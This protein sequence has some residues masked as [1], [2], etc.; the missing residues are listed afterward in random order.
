MPPKVADWLMKEGHGDDDDDEDDNDRSAGEKNR[1]SKL[2]SGVND[3]LRTIFRPFNMH[4][5]ENVS[6]LFADIVGFTQMS[7]NKTAEQ[8]VGLL[9]DLFGRFDLLCGQHGCEKISTLG[10][11]YYC[12]AGCPEPRPD[13]AGCCVDMGLSMIEA[14]G[15]FDE[16]RG[17]NVSMRVGVH[18]GTVLCGIVGVKRFKFDVWSN[19]VTLANQME[20]TGKPSQVHVTQATF[21]LLDQQVYFVE[22]GPVYHGLLASE[23]SFLSSYLICWFAGLKT[24]FVLGRKSDQ[25]TEDTATAEF[26]TM[27][28]D[29]TDPTISLPCG[30]SVTTVPIGG[31][32]VN[33]NNSKKANSLPSILDILDEVTSSDSNCNLPCDSAPL[34]TSRSVSQD[35]KKKNIHYHAQRSQQDE[36]APLSAGNWQLLS[37]TRLI[38]RLIIIGPMSVELRSSNA[39]VCPAGQNGR[40]D[41]LSLFPSVESFMKAQGA[42]STPNTLQRRPTA[43]NAQQ[44]NVPDMERSPT[45]MSLA[46]YNKDALAE[47]EGAV[48]ENSIGLHASLSRFHQ[49]RKQSDLAMIRCIQEDESHR[50]Y[51]MRPPLSQVTLFFIDAAMEKVNNAITTKIMIDFDVDICRNIEPGHTSRIN[52]ELVWH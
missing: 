27:W 10:D 42:T 17:E 46:L 49:L 21:A 16:E 14:I 37:I 52:Q 3:Q 9:N 23:Y 51:F 35:R 5:M 36:L 30:S 39:I 20:S 25:S 2:S 44:L 28:L 29:E 12:V 40:T 8:L 18:T 43:A 34:R 48:T 31:S 4:R 15:R 1:G 41:E 50:V 33:T 22:E 45:S 32:N 24:Y 26:A 6:I 47:L 38:I 11:C 13:H 19:D 7:S